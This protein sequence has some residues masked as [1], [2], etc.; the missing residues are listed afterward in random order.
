M[1]LTGTVLVKYERR[2][3]GY[4]TYGLLHRD[5]TDSCTPPG[6]KPDGLQGPSPEQLPAIQAEDAAPPAVIQQLVHRVPPLQDTMSRT[7]HCQKCSQAP[8]SLQQLVTPQEA[9]GHHTCSPA[10]QTLY[11]S[12]TT[13]AL[14]WACLGK[15]PPNDSSR[16]AKIC[17]G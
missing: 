12:K 9:A 6:G 15:T 1:H 8:K 2:A 3:V 11:S 14:E 17:A 10:I 4:L 16:S 7:S 13:C 5:S